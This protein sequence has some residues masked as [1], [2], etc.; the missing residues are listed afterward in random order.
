MSTNLRHHVALSHIKRL[1]L[2]KVD[3]MLV[4]LLLV[5]DDHVQ[6]RPRILISELTPGSIVQV[7]Y[8]FLNF[9]LA[10]WHLQMLGNVDFYP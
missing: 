6:L 1:F 5:L 3:I 8:V 7:L 9:L 2:L 10:E 4:S